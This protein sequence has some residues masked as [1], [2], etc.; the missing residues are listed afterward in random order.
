M[1]WLFTYTFIG[2]Q[3][4]VGVGM[5]EDSPSFTETKA[6]ERWKNG[7]PSCFLCRRE[8]KEDKHMYAVRVSLHI[9][10]LRTNSR[11]SYS[12]ETPA[13][14]IVSLLVSG[15]VWRGNSISYMLDSFFFLFVKAISHS[16]IF[17]SFPL[18][19]KMQDDEKVLSD[20]TRLLLHYEAIPVVIR[21]SICFRLIEDKWNSSWG[22]IFFGRITEL[23]LIYTESL[24]QTITF[25]LAGLSIS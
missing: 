14:L 25:N 1:S 8:K 20:I 2:A 21:T 17:I 12:Q 6:K 11:I 7:T 24:L 18:T 9:H 23:E 3:G 5:L 15:S 13:S 19:E 10:V 22:S 4:T 16:G